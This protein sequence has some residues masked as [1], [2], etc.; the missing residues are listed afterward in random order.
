V[1]IDLKQLSA[2]LGLSP[3]TVSRALNGYTDV[4]AKTRERV[5]QMAQEVGYQPNPAARRLARGQADAVGIVYPLEAGDLGDP[6]FVSV[7]E[8]MSDRLDTEQ[9]D[10]LIASARAQAELRTYDRLLRG[11]RVDG[12]IV[13]RTRVEDARIDYLR[14][15]GFPFVAYGRTGHCEDFSW[16]DFDN[17][18]GGAL[19]VQELVRLGHR[20]IACVLAPQ[21]LNFAVQ[22]RAGF[23]RALREA[24]LPV[25]AEAVV[26]TSLSRRAG[27]AAAQQL[28]ALR[29]RP[30]A[31]FV[32]DNLCGIGVVRALLDQQIALGRDISVIVY[33]GVPPD[34]L[35]VGQSIAAIEQPTAYEAGRT[36]ADMLL[37]VIRQPGAPPQHVLRQPVFAGG[38]SVGPAP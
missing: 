23:L 10:L 19:A 31:I 2:K 1:S 3:T 34:T 32:D 12:V 16:F 33:D 36:L 13:A 26:E 29:P 14:A 17:E 35:L 25:R 22:R 27:Y 6:N 18:A 7:V 24:N 21:H 8:G 15:A 20:D 9:M 30:T 4:S 11:G 37:Q 5:A 38:S 28:L